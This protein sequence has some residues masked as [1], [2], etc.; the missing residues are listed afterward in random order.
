MTEEQEFEAV[1]DMM[2]TEGAKILLEDIRRNLKASDTIKVTPMID[3]KTG[4]VLVSQTD[5]MLK[6][7]GYVAALEW[8]VGI[9][10]HYRD[11]HYQGQETQDEDQL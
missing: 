5:Q 1:K 11:N 9:M 2:L 7:Q 8:V 6:Q 4:S 3:T 10:Q